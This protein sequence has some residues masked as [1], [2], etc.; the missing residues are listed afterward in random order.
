[1]GLDRITLLALVAHRSRDC[2]N[3]DLAVA[4]VE[5]CVLPRGVLLLLRC[6]HI[7]SPELRSV[8]VRPLVRNMLTHWGGIARQIVWCCDICASPQF[9]PGSSSIGAAMVNPALR[10]WGQ[11]R[12]YP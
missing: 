1:M 2:R 7:H 11:S 12:F 4:I 3:P 6:F 5:V 9:R 10:S 8:L